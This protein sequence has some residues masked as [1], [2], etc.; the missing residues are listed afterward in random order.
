MHLALWYGELYHF[1]VERIPQPEKNLPLEQHQPAQFGGMRSQQNCAAM[2]CAS[3]S[4]HDRVAARKPH[5]SRNAAIMTASWKISVSSTSQ[6]LQ[7]I[8]KM[9]GI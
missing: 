8:R 7:P 2:R 5:D 9:H 6:A 4:L 1:L 3:R